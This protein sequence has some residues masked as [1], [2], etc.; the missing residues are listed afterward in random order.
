MQGSVAREGVLWK[1]GTLAMPKIVPQL[2]GL[3][4]EMLEKLAALELMLLQKPIISGRFSGMFI[5]HCSRVCKAHSFFC[6][7]SSL[8]QWKSF[9]I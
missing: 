4:Q 8:R 6:A 5:S 2:M 9:E 1:Q 7:Y 3:L